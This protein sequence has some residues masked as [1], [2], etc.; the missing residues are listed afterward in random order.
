MLGAHIV[1]R[2]HQQP[3]YLLGSMVLFVLSC[4]SLVAVDSR[5]GNTRPQPHRGGHSG[6]SAS[7]AS[8]GELAA[9]PPGARAPQVPAEHLQC[10]YCDWGTKVFLFVNF[11][12]HRWLPH[13]YLQLKKERGVS[14]LTA[15]YSPLVQNR[16][17][18]T[19]FLFCFTPWVFL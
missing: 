12:Q 19:C 13:C 17:M 15:P 16:V 4:R 14:V 9:V 1:T 5:T 7:A 10:G 6:G 8:P 2:T 18:K 3:S 11:N